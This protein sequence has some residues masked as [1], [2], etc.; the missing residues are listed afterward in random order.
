MSRPLALSFILAGSAAYAEA[1]KVV[2]DIAPVQS[3]V[4]QVMEGVGEPAVLVDPGASPHGYALR[5]SQARALQQAD[6]V[7]WVGEPLTPWLEPIL[8]DVAHD[9]EKVELLEEEGTRVLEGRVIAVF[10]GDDDHDD[11]KDHDH[12]DHDDHKNDDHADH[13]DHKDHDHAAH[14]DDDDH[15]DHDHA[16]HDDHQEARHDDDHDD[17]GYDDH[18]HDH[19]GDDPHAWLDPMNGKAWLAAIAAH[20]SKADPENA[21]TYAANAA[22]AQADLEAQVTRL[23][24]LLEPHHEERYVVFH[25]AY[26][27]FESRFDLTPVGAISLG[28]AS[29]PSAARLAALRDEIAEIGVVCAFSEPQFNDGLVDAVTGSADVKAGVLDPLGTKFETGP[30]LYGQILDDL[31][32][33]IADCLR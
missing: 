13:D 11:H 21:A 5:P 22:R 29:S 23:A 9:A 7:F 20:L 14:D 33:T 12:A 27:Y 17:H 15:K 25:D 31:G 18:G 16:D 30:A 10:S 8:E 1:P 26:Q 6:I 24:A 3:L 4:A 28:D 2:T 32:N 19:D